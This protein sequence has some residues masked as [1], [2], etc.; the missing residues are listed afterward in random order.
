M[1]VTLCLFS[2]FLSCSLSLHLQIQAILYLCQEGSDTEHVCHIL[3]T[4]SVPRSF[5]TYVFDCD[6]VLW[7]IS[8]EDRCRN[9]LRGAEQVSQ[10]CISNTLKILVLCLGNLSIRRSTYGSLQ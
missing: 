2:L 1:L 9:S 3:D 7:G 6:G 8:D 5:E 4:E 10:L